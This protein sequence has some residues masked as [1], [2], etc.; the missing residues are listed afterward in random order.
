MPR[1]LCELVT[2]SWKR[3]YASVTL[4]PCTTE[5]INGSINK[6]AFRNDE[7]ITRNPYFSSWRAGTG[8]QI[9]VIARHA[10]QIAEIGW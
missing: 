4:L 8:S 5:N 10:G 2:R 6:V 1:A 9:D 7:L 3:T